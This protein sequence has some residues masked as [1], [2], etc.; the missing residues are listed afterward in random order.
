LDNSGLFCPVCKRKN[1]RDS[2][3]CSYCG[4]SLR[5]LF[6]NAANATTRNTEN[7]IHGPADAGELALD[8][9]TPAE[10]IAIYV[11]GTA[12]PVFIRSEKEIII[13]RKTEET[14]S[15]FILD[16]SEL[17]GF[18][19]GLSRRH[20]VIR[21][22]ESGYEV[23][24]LSSTNG[25]WLNDERLVPNKP[26]PLPNRSQIRAGRL[27]FLVLYRSTSEPAKSA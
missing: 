8:A 10:G 25:T 16:F 2:L 18:Q 23:V 22:V 27:R 24:D 11:T 17:D 7:P 1:K 20:A 5:E 26:Y 12:K 14:A 3:V 4:T 19:M 6:I 21:Q 15:E 13:G 9:L